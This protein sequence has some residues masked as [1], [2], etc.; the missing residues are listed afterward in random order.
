MGFY[1][2]NKGAARTSKGVLAAANNLKIPLAVIATWALLREEADHLRVLVGL[3][4]IVGALFL[5]DERRGES[6]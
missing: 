3:G 2:W 5:A 6:A 1:L 4:V